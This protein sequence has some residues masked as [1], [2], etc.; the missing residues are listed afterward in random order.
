VTDRIGV[1]SNPRSRRNRHRGLGAVRAVVARHPRVLHAELD[2]VGGIPAVLREFA[3]REVELVVVNGGDG[4]IQA[5]LT[6]LFNGGTFERPPLLS[7]IPA[8]GAN[9]I[10][11]DVGCPGR[12]PGEALARL[13]D[14]VLAGDRGHRGGITRIA[15]PTLSVMRGA[16]RR[17]VYGM[18]FGAGAFYEGTRLAR[19]ELR[20]RG[21]GEPLAAGLAL[22]LCIARA[23]LPRRP[24][25]VERSSDS[26]LRGEP[27]TI[28]VDG[29]VAVGPDRRYALVLATTLDR[30]MLGLRPF[31][32]TGDGR[33]RYT[34]IEAPP[35]RLGR[36]LFPI[37]R[38]R[39]RPWMAGSGYISGVANG[40]VL[41][42]RRPTPMVLDGETLSPPSGG[43]PV[44]LA[45]DRSVVFL[46]C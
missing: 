13:I 23:L 45:S 22:G 4:T 7:V 11:R 16:D 8:G 28:A 46:R 18:F 17:L 35:R 32:G 25:T 19:E 2:G 41:A 24:A 3:G 21:I 37:L 1:I 39:P 27:M 29:T 6:A 31:W 10:A 20:P 42:M 5:T 14:L 34:L 30:L 9:L 40:L 15:R 44:V 12:S 36:A 33:I 43:A 38:G 26:L